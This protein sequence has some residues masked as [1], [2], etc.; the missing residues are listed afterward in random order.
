MTSL[1]WLRNSSPGSHLLKC[2]CSDAAPSTS[3]TLAGDGLQIK[4][5]SPEEEILGKAGVG[6]M[7]TPGGPGPRS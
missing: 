4:R 3:L 6:D 7:R 5:L 2:V 1:L